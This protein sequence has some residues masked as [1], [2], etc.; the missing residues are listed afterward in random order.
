[1]KPCFHIVTLPIISTPNL[2]HVY[3]G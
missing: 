2:V 1:M 3:F